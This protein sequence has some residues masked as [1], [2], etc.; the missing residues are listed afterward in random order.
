MKIITSHCLLS[1]DEHLSIRSTLQNSMARGLYLALLD[2]SQHY[3]VGPAA[4][5]D[6]LGQD[7]QTLT[8]G[9]DPAITEY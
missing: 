7:R 4:G 1:C 3:N 9:G 6:S 8:V 2:C 5:A